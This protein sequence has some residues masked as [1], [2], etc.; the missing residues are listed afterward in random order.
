MPTSWRNFCGRRTELAK[1]FLHNFLFFLSRSHGDS[2]ILKTLGCLSNK[3]RVFPANIHSFLW[4][5]LTLWTSGTQKDHRGG[6]PECVFVGSSVWMFLSCQSVNVCQ[7]LP[8]GQTIDRD[9]L[10]VWWGGGKQLHRPL[11]CLRSF[12][13]IGLFLIRVFCVFNLCGR[14]RRLGGPLKHI[15]F[16]S[17]C[18]SIKDDSRSDFKMLFRKSPTPRRIIR[19]YGL[20]RRSMFSSSSYKAVAWGGSFYKL[21]PPTCIL[22]LLVHEASVCLLSGALSQNVEIHIGF[23]ELKFKITIKLV[24]F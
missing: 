21:S 2:L 11:S 10:D 7:Y 22:A 14:R 13:V 24:V 1:T 12:S 20:W 16:C 19:L 23:N 5:I 8:D 6:S 3:Q 4:C 18:S 15:E 17:I 9:L